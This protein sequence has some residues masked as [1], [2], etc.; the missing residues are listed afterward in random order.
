MD[1]KQPSEMEK[2]EAMRNRLAEALGPDT[3]TLVEDFIDFKTA[4]I[5][6][7]RINHKRP[8]PFQFDE[9]NGLT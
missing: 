6:L 4:Q 2:L 1:G 9:P 5:K 7:V 8:P 3:A